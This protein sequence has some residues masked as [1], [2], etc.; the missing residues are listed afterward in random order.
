MQAFGNGQATFVSLR[1]NTCNL[2]S[3]TKI[4]MKENSTAKEGTRKKICDGEILTIAVNSSM[5]DG[6]GNLSLE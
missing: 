1:V 3:T 5:H 2:N 6:G 4:R